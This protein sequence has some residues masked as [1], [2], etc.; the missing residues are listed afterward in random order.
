VAR[1]LTADE[2]LAGAHH[3]LVLEGGPAPENHTARIRTFKPELVIFVDAAQMD[4][5]AGTIR[6]LSLD[7]IDGMSASTHSLPL[8]MLARFITLETGCRVAVLG[9][10][11]QQNEIGIEITPWVDAATKEIVEVMLEIF[12]PSGDRKD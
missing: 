6:W 11:P 4:E 10:Q 5:P 12:A 7:A 9:I 8:S 1:A 2:R 3:L